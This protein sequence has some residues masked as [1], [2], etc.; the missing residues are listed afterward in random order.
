[1]LQTEMFLFSLP[2][3]VRKTVKTGKCGYMWTSSSKTSVSGELTTSFASWGK[4]VDLVD[5]LAEPNTGASRHS[6]L[7]MMRSWMH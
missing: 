5:L 1:M 2:F 6:C 4:E 7:V 3:P